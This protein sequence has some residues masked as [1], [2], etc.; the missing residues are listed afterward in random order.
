[1]GQLGVPQTK[2]VSF[3]KPETNAG[4]IKPFKDDDPNLVSPNGAPEESTLK[5]GMSEEEVQQRLVNNAWEDVANEYNARQE[6]EC[7]TDEVEWKDFVDDAIE[8]EE[9]MALGGFTALIGA[10]SITCLTEAAISYMHHAFSWTFLDCSIGLMILCVA[11]TLRLWDCGHPTEGKFVLG[12]VIVGGLTLGLSIPGIQFA[13]TLPTWFLP[14]VGLMT[15]TAALVVY[16]ACARFFY[17][18]C[19]PRCCR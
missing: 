1:M 19:L 6:A 3:E 14:I 2:T 10:G 13:H 16:V 4:E 15:L 7:V 8:R 12:C 11:L 9:T 5:R 17:W 18:K